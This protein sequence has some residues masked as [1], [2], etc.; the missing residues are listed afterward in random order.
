[1]FDSLWL[2]SLEIIPSKRDGFPFD[3]PMIRSGFRLDFEGPVT[4]FAGENGAGKSTLLE[5]LALRCGFATL[6]ASETEFD[7]SL[8]ALR[9]LGDELQLKWRIRATQGFFVR[10]EDFF[11]FQKRINQT[12]RELELQIKSYQAELGSN[13][14][15][16][17]GIERAIGFIRGQIHEL[18]SR[19][20]EDA[21]ARSH[22]EAF[23]NAFQ[24]RISSPGL[25]LLDEPEAALSPLRQMAF[26]KLVKDATEAGSQ[27][28]IATHSPLL[29]RL[30]G[31]QIIDFDQVP[32]Q[33]NEWEELASVRLWRAF[34]SSPA[35][36]L[37][38]L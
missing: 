25:Y 23:L 11:G 9:L 18:D 24:A 36:F 19:Y 27:F 30:D 1:M 6:G 33:P 17:K 16:N 13:R 8:K 5:V 15:E 32:P 35:G 37:R 7:S 22:G 14:E 20:G 12:R 34:W 3:L 26:L 2:R 10:A 4:F 38:R 21:D 28:I 29:L 31:A